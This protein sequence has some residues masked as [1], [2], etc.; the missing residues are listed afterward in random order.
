MGHFEHAICP[1][2]KTFKESLAKILELLEDKKEN[3][4][5]M[6]C[7]GGIRCEK[8]ALYLEE[9]GFQNVF[10]VIDSNSINY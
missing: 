2:V 9:N 5:L 4:I 6:Y 8:A 10:S 7:T 1:E 3:K